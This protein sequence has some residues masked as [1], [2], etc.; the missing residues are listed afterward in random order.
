MPGAFIWHT[1]TRKWLEWKGISAHVGSQMLELEPTRR[2]AAQVASCF[3][4]LRKNGVRL[5]HIDLGGGLGIRYTNE[6]PPLLKD[7]ARAIISAIKPL[8]CRLLLEPGRSI[9]GPAGILLMR[10]ILTKSNCDRNF[11]VVDAAMN[12]FL[13]PALYGGI[14]PMTPVMRTARPSAVIRADMVGPVCETGDS[15]L[16]DWPIEEV[17][18]G[19]I[20]A[21]WG[22]GAYGFVESSNYNSRPRPAEI[23]VDG[24]K[25]QVIKRRETRAD[26][27]RGEQQVRK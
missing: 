15:F 27:L 18:P 4:D 22:A 6:N 14:H 17:Q 25:S 5:Q 10:V 21:L 23:L 11:I 19:D 24:A 8:G 16:K 7:Y 26:L 2:A 1:K 12:D 13:R 9:V 20:L 3:V